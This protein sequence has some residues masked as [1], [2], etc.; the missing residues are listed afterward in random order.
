M[1]LK[2]ALELLKLAHSYIEIKT[3]LYSKGKH[4]LTLEKDQLMLIVNTGQEFKNFLLDEADLQKDP[5]ILITEIKN[6]LEIEN[7]KIELMN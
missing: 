3:G 7:K 5:V 2:N 6:L 4:A 1:S